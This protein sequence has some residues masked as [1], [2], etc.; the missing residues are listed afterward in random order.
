[1]ESNAGMIVRV[2]KRLKAA[3]GYH[4]LGMTRHA[5][6]CLDSLPRTRQDWTFWPGRRIPSR[7]VRPR[8]RRITSPPPRPWRSSS[9]C[10]RRRPGMRSG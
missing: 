10:C 7:R 4:E 8:T 1:M 2:L 6:R 3:V 9:A 5:L